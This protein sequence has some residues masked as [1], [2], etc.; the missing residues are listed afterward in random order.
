MLWVEVEQAKQLFS[1]WWA[2]PEGQLAF[3]LL[4]IYTPEA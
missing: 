3:S 4:R 1:L 2:D